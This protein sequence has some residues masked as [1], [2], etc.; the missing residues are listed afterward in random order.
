MSKERKLFFFL[1]PK[2]GSQ[3]DAERRSARA[4]EDSYIIRAFRVCKSRPPG[5]ALLRALEAA[6]RPDIISPAPRREQNATEKPRRSKPREKP[7]AFNY[8]SLLHPHQRLLR[9]HLAGRHHTGRPGDPSSAET[10][11]PIRHSH[12]LPN[13]RDSDL[14]RRRK[15]IE[16]DLHDRTRQTLEHPRNRARQAALRMGF[17]STRSSRGDCPESIAQG[18]F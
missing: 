12:S 3:S 15:I 13:L 10:E 16:R 2:R 8:D 17:A 7:R 4:E 18:K 6:S 1:L 5:H 11:Q 9:D 14:T